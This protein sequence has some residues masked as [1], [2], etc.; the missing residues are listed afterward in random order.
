[1]TPVRAVPRSASEM[2]CNSKSTV[3]D[4]CYSVIKEEQYV[5]QHI[6]LLVFTGGPS[7]DLLL[8]QAIGKA[9]CQYHA[10][11]CTGC[12]IY[13]RVLNSVVSQ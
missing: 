10:S 6:F 2:P 4:V 8:Q 9:F 1:M 11:L 7:L 12:S 3:L 13:P 5:D